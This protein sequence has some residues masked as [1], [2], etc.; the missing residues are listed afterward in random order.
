MTSL[1]HLATIFDRLRSGYHYTPA[2]GEVF[3][4]L[5]NRFDAYQAAFE[6][7][8]MNLQKHRENVVYLAAGA[9]QDPGKQARKMGLFVLVLVEWMSNEHA[10]VVPDFFETWWHVGDLPHLSS[11]RY[12][13]YMEQVG[14]TDRADVGRV[15]RLLT[16]YGFAHPRADGAFQFRTAA[17]RFLDLCMEAVEMTE[18]AEAAGEQAEDDATP[19]AAARSPVSGS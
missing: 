2:D 13:E 15:I 9:S 7:F 12:R 16:K 14:V 1:P 11:D 18:D 8:G 5:W 6:A 19:N 3:R 10:T 17:Y 4:A